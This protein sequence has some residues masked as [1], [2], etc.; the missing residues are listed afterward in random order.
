ML[1]NYITFFIHHIV[2]RNQNISLKRGDNIVI[3]F[4]N[5][6][7]YYMKKDL[8]EHFYLAKSKGEVNKFKDTFLID[9]CLRKLHNNELEMMI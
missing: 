2:Y 6:V 3:I 9:E 1:R 5:K 8:T 7:K 4:K